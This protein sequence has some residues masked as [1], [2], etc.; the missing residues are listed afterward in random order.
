[1]ASPVIKIRRG[2]DIR[3]IGAANPVF[4]EIGL[5]PRVAV[6]PPD[7]RGVRVRLL[8]KEGDT[9]KVGTPVLQDKKDTDLHL[10]SPVSGK[11]VAINR[12]EKRALLE[13]VIETDGRQ[14]AESFL[15]FSAEQIKGLS[16]Q[17]LVEHLTRTGLWPALRQRPFSHIASRQEIPKSIFVQAINTEPLA[18]DISEIFHQN[19]ETPE[20]FRA[21]LEVLT[22]LTDGAV[23]VC[24][25]AG[26]TADVLKS[27]P[28]HD[29]VRLHHFS[30]P[31]P[32]GNVSTLI[33]YIDPIE[34][35]DI[36]WYIGA[37][38]VIRI[39]KTLAE[40][41][42]W[43]QKFVAVVGEGIEKEARTYKETV[44]GAPVAFLAG[45]KVSEKYRYISGSVLS[46]RDVGLNGHLGYF[47]NLLTGIPAGGQRE[48]L[49]W[50]SPG[51]NKFS[52]SKTFLS[53]LRPGGEVS[54]D[55]NKNGGDRAIVLNHIY[56][57][58][59]PLDVMTYFL[60][61]AVIGGDIEEAERLG[62]LECDE[63]DF[64]LCSFVCPSKTDIGGIIRD[65]LDLIEKEG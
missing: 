53:A 23:H 11:V 25:A 5:P 31:H 56:D 20:A 36:V 45:G 28:G 44:I 33:H 32:A 63:E 46:G 6:Q 51:W 50:L 40:G 3:L 9:V 30:G 43:P 17:D 7:F 22:K 21:G 38:D 42:Y 26:A 27:E 19:P 39:G 16:R 59:V 64:A 24:A 55:T 1:M 4:Q 58:Y 14:E 65:G 47:H 52:F 13:I 35:G 41:A 48:F 60:I 29:R 37:E 49:G 12:G 54:L 18:L 34:K 62:I 57:K 10:V 2:R 8:A 15:K 61:R